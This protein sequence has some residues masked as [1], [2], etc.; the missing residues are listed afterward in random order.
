MTELLADLGTA[1]AHRDVKPENIL[2]AKVARRIEPRRIAS[3][4]VLPF[5]NL[6]SNPS[7]EYFVRTTA[8][9][10]TCW[11]FTAKW[12]GLPQRRFEWS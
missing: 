12:R 2:F 5:E 7:Q 9:S 4:A 3:I 10:V 8:P 6:S 1:F 11:R